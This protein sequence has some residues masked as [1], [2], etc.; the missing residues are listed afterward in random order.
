MLIMRR[1]RSCQK[2][3]IATAA[4]LVALQMA[5]P[6][7]AASDDRGWVDSIGDKIS[8]V[9]AAIM[10]P[11]KGAGVKMAAQP[12]AMRGFSNGGGEDRDPFWHHLEDAGYQLKEIKTEISLI[13]NVDIEFV[14]IR[15]LSEADRS[16][17]ERQLEIDKKRRPGMLGAIKRRIIRTLIEASDYKEMRIEE[18]TISLL[19]LPAA[20]FVL[21]PVEAPMAEEHDM[22]FRMLQNI[23]HQTEKLGSAKGSRGI[24]VGF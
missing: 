8:S 12:T 23:Q 5:G 6:A 2:I 9:G 11:F 15:E 1:P 4:M 7:A 17:L 10:S 18:L 16:S 19:P 3:I 22:L 24:G 14:L 20:T 21:A 13:P